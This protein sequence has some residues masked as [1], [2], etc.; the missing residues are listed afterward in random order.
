MPEIVAIAGV[1][2]GLGESLARRFSA[3]GCRVA[4]LARSQGYLSALARD[5]G[6]DKA[7]PVPADVTRPEEVERAFRKIREIFGPPDVLIHHAGNAKWGKLAD[8][9]PGDFEKAWRVCA[10][11]GFLCVREAVPAMVRQ[12]RG[13]ILFTGATSAVR[14][15]ADAVV[16]SSAKFA[17]R[18][19][20]DAL[21]RELWPQ[22]IH[23]AHVIIDG[24]IGPR[25]GSAGE[26]ETG[27]PRMDPDA[28]AQ[29]YWALVRQ[30]KSAWTFELDLRPSREGFFT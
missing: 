22:G 4:L 29:S 21:A 28:I 30:E 5:L 6:T 17:V 13:A 11:A 12:G 19:L 3:E 16:F 23:V 7:L 20:A 27:E 2:P 18:G 10:W 25:G 8:V 26:D 14:G 9:G 1:G 24:V 15:R